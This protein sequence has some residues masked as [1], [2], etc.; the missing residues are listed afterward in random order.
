MKLPHLIFA[1]CLVPIA[2]SQAPKQLPE[3]F[4]DTLMAG[5]IDR[6]YDEAFA[7][8]GLSKLKPQAVQMLK[9]QTKTALSMYGAPYAYEIIHDEDLSPS[10]HRFVYLMKAES[11]PVTW[12]FIY[13]KA[14]EDWYLVQINFVD[15]FQNISNRK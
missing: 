9:A 3:Q 7:G 13:Y 14:K 2:F 5:E 4:F 1:L 8:S 11:Y 6:A 12:E 10:L 15:H